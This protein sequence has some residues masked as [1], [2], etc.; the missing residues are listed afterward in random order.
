[1][2]GNAAQQPLKSVVS[3]EVQARL[4]KHILDDEPRV[5][6][7]LKSQARL[8]AQLNKLLQALS[9]LVVL[10]GLQFPLSHAATLSRIQNKM[11][12]LSSRLS[13]IATRLSRIQQRLET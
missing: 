11:A 3:A 4:S 2:E 9:T 6:K 7:L 13:V 5:D 1:M 8:T 12:T 10:P